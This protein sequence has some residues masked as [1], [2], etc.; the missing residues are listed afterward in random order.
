LAFFGPFT[1]A[2][3]AGL[4]VYADTY[5]SME[6]AFGER[7]AI[8]TSLLDAVRE[9]NYGVKRGQ[10]LT[11]LDESMQQRIAEYRNHA[12]GSLSALKTEIG[13]VPRKDA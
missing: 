3:M 11:G 5:R 1:I 13:P 8:P 12:Y 10:G 2:D 7:F 9:G 4:D 6:A